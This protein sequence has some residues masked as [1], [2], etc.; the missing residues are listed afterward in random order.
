MFSGLV[1]INCNEY[2]YPER[3]LAMLQTYSPGQVF[4]VSKRGFPGEGAFEGERRG[5]DVVGELG[6]RRH[7]VVDHDEE[8]EVLEGAHGQFVIG[9]RDHGVAATHDQGADAALARCED[10]LGECGRGHLAPVAAQVPDA[11]R[12]P[13]GRRA[14]RDDLGPDRRLG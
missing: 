8:F 11:R 5:D 1:I 2:G 4:T 13:V 14:G 3:L 12:R 9:E 6:G 7:P 10:L